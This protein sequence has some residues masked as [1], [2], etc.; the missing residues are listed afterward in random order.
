MKFPHCEENFHE[1][2]TMK[3]LHLALGAIMFITILTGCASISLVSSWKDAA[4]NRG[5]AV[6]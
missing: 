5:I 3:T 1:G 2:E 6:G 4:S